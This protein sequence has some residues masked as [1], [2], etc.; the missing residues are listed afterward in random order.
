M[1]ELFSREPDVITVR[2]G[3][4]LTPIPVGKEVDSLSAILMDDDYY[5]LVR[6]NSEFIDGIHV[7]SEQAL[8]CLKAKAFLDLTERKA[9]GE[10]IDGKDIRKHR[11]DVMKLTATIARQAADVPESIKNDLAQFIIT[12]RDE[13]PNI[14]DVLTQVGVRNTSLDDIL[15]LIQEIFQLPE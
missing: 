4:H 6:E 13:N 12:V 1:L 3:V 7:A 2:E 10:R 9:N 11:S 8:V 15:T 14:K 5:Q